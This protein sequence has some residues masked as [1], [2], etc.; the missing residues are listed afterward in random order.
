MVY[1]QIKFQLVSG[2][3]PNGIIWE[4]AKSNIIVGLLHLVGFCAG[5]FLFVKKKYTLAT[6]LSLA[7]FAIGEV[8]F[9][10]TNG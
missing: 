2:F 5:L 1:A 3:I 4:I 6:I 10:F 7:L 9:F 8:Y